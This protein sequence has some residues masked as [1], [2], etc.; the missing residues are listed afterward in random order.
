MFHFADQATPLIRWSDS[1]SDG[2]RGQ[3]WHET[4][5]L[6]TVPHY[7]YV[8]WNEGRLVLDAQA[9]KLGFGGTRD[10]TEPLPFSSGRDRALVE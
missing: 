9:S 2:I 5:R 7:I 8:R 3:K 1:R 6:A 10:F 4:A